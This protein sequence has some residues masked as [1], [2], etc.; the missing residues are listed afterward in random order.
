M[1]FYSLNSATQWEKSTDVEFHLHVTFGSRVMK[2]K[3]ERVLKW[4]R[5]RRILIAN[6]YYIYHGRLKVVVKNKRSLSVINRNCH[7]EKER[8]TV[9]SFVLENGWGDKEEREGTFNTN[10]FS[11]WARRRWQQLFA[12][13]LVCGDLRP[14][15]PLSSSLCLVSESQN[16]YIVNRFKCRC[17]KDRNFH[18]FVQKYEDFFHQQIY[19]WIV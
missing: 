3:I 13:S 8:E 6:V 5:A 15:I 17:W 9:V 2:K 7:T 14:T 18:R 10:Y 1:S 16:T 11:H 4:T 12:S 19:L